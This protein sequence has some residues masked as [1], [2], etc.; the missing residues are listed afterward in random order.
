MRRAVFAHFRS[1]AGPNPWRFVFL[2]LGAMAISAIGQSDRVGSAIAGLLDTD[3]MMRAA[4]IASG[5]T[6]GAI[7]VTLI[8]IDDA[9][10]ERRGA[11]DRSPRSLVAETARLAAGKGAA[12]VV[13]DV[14]LARPS[15]KPEED[16]AAAALLAGWTGAMPPLALV[17]RPGETP[18]GHAQRAADAPIRLV[19]SEVAP[20]ADGVVRRWRPIVPAPDGQALG[21]PPLFALA[22]FDPARGLAGYD[23]AVAA[24]TTTLPGS[25]AIPY[26]VGGAGARLRGEGGAPLWRLVPASALLEPDGRMRPAAEIGASPFA[27]R[28][29]LIGA[30]HRES[31]DR[32]MTPLGDLPG[33]TILA[34][35]I[36]SA[37][38]TLRG[39]EPGRVGRML[40]SSV[41]FVAMAAL[42]L[43]LRPLPATLA[44]A[45]LA[46]ASLMLLGFALPPGAAFAIVAAA[47]GMT[48]VLAI[49][50]GVGDILARLARK[51][52]WN[53]VLK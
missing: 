20:D 36:I 24:R 25:V 52:G 13:I 3:L 26:L 28:L 48:A 18:L 30:A 38:A 40:I 11:L 15:A 5:A 4:N 6:R 9:A 31:G 37:P 53:A 43:F 45:T 16:A 23:A 32:H 10:M 22:A 19:S 21:S 29:V 34:N 51:E 1:Q 14:D 33:A 46:L 12:A 44:I 7:P 35:M 49:L 39:A 41:L 27:G 8:L 47:V 50:D 42:G 17:V 2:L